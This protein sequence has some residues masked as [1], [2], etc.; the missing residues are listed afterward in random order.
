M[1]DFVNHA[2]PLAAGRVAATPIASAVSPDSAESKAVSY[3]LLVAWLDTRYWWH[4][5]TCSLTL[6][7]DTHVHGRSNH[8]PA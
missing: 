1:F 3:E 8:R 4:D 5:S 2:S 6:T 7:K